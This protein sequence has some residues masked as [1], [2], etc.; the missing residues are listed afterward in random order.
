MHGQHE[1][2]TDIDLEYGEATIT[3]SEKTSKR[4]NMVKT[5]ICVAA[6]GSVAAVAT[7]SS[8]RIATTQ[9]TGYTTAS[10]HLSAMSEPT[11]T[12]R[13]IGGGMGTPAY[14]SVPGFEK[15]L[16]KQAQGTY[17]QW[18][19]PLVMPSDC[20]MESW[21][22]LTTSND[23]GVQACD[24]EEDTNDKEEDKKDEDKKEE[25]KKDDGYS[26]PHSPNSPHTESAAEMQ[27]QKFLDDHM[28]E[29][30][31]FVAEHKDAIDSAKAEIEASLKTGQFDFTHYQKQLQQLVEQH[32]MEQYRIKLNEFTR[33]HQAE[34]QKFL[35]EHKEAIDD[36]QDRIQA[37]IGSGQFD[38][39]HY[40]QQLAQYVTEHDLGQ[41]QQEIMQF[42]EEH[43]AQIEEFVAAHKEAIQE[44][45]D[46]IAELVGS[47]M[48]DFRH[49]QQQIADLVQQNT[50][51]KQQY[52]QY[53]DQIEDALIEDALIEDA[54]ENGPIIVEYGINKAGILRGNAYRIL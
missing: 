32:D 10:R 49:Y 36:V 6:I 5:I 2:L 34:I 42:M 53:Q 54:A 35:S 48:F 16:T 45:Q 8:T 4:S 19:I 43:K 21:G 38:F 46:D 18:C 28:G 17:T 50:L 11:A 15:C 24:T 9:E 3:R 30:K 51:K 25:G 1:Q 22:A 47:G 41:Y 20:V 52:Q 44:V 13:V 40:K 12:D 7:V 39:S 33:S 27:M 23:I 26:G 37:A 29:I 14:L 31:K